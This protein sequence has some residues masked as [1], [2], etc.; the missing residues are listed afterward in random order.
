MVSALYNLNHLTVI[1][2]KVADQILSQKIVVNYI[3]TLSPSSL[4]KDIFYLSV[5]L[6]VTNFS[7]QLIIKIPLG[8]YYFIKEVAKIRIQPPQWLISLVNFRD[9]HYL[10]ITW[11]ILTVIQ[12]LHQYVK[13]VNYVYPHG[14]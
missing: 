1:F 3:G 9:Q 13:Y 8:D 2:S 10:V 7:K 5:F 12:Q 6:G 14:M 4:R 11:P